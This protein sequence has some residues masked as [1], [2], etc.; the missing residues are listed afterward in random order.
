MVQT[1]H[2]GACVSLLL[3][4]NI[5]SANVIPLRELHFN[6]D[7][8]SESRGTRADE[9]YHL[10]K[11]VKPEFYKIT[12]T[13]NFDNFT[14]I[15]TVDITVSAPNGTD[16][17]S[18]HYDKI[19][20]DTVIV[21]CNN[22][23]IPLNDSYVE[24]TNIFTLELETPLISEE[25]C[26]IHIDYEGVL[27]DDMAG[28]YRSSYTTADGEERWL[29][30]T[31]FEPTD[32]RRAFPCFDEPGLKAAF[33]INIRRTKDLKSISNMNLLSSKD[34]ADGL[35]EDSFAVSPL[36]STYLV[37][38]IVSDFKQLS[39]NDDHHLYRIWVKGDALTQASYSMSISPGI[40][41]FMENFTAIQYK[42]P[43]LDQAAVPDFAAGAME[44]WGL[45]T[46][47]ERLLLYSEGTSTSSNKQNIASV[48][49]HEFAHQWFGDLVSP[50][51]WDYLWLN[52]GF[53]TYFEFFATQAVE[54]NW[55]LDHQFVV[56]AHQNALAADSSA[57]THP[58]TASVHT[59]AQINSIFDTISYDKAG[60]IIRTAEHFL[61][62]NTFVKGLR[63][64]LGI[65]AFEAATADDLFDALA[66]QAD[67][68][69][70]FQNDTDLNV[71]TILKS[72]TEQAGYPYI[73]VQ[74][75]ENGIHISQK[76]FLISGETEEEPAT[77]WWVPITY[78]TNNSI[79]FENTAP[80]VWLR[81]ISE[82]DI[83]LTLA[84][85]E[86][87]ILN[88]QETAFY[89]VIYD[90]VNYELLKDYLNS[91]NYI[92][93][94]PLNRAQLLDD[95]LYLARAGLL[96]YSTA[97]DLTT[98][99]AAETDFVPWVSFYRALTFLNT[100]FAGTEDYDLFKNY[101]LQLIQNLYRSVGF[102][103]LE[104]DE[105]P[106]KL[107]RVTTLTW[108]CN[109]NYDLCLN[110]ASALFRTWT[111]N[112][113][114]INRIPP[115]LRS[116]VYCSAVSNGGVDEWAFL[117][118]EFLKSKV[119]SDQVL[120][121]S[122]LGCTRDVTLLR[123][124]LTIAITPESK[125]RLQDAQT[126]FSA[127][128]SRP[129]GVDVAFDFLSNNFVAVQQYFAS[130]SGLRNIISGIASRMTTHAQHQKLSDFVSQHETDLG[131]ALAAA[132]AAVETVTVNLAWFDKYRQDI[133]EWMVAYTE[134][135]TSGPTTTTG[136]TTTTGPPTSET[137]ITTTD[138]GTSLSCN[139]LISI[140]ILT[141][142]MVAKY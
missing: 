36:M 81:N 131:S 133:S 112:T 105:H 67:A 90:D 107:I 9:D 138:A 94:H 84:D 135:T 57:T 89:R 7:R 54:P 68:D 71:K 91:D 2:L 141:G 79:D 59:P 75:T 83:E 122:A 22:V 62:H 52:E 134:T 95:S 86:W 109:F 102:N 44:N 114:R 119:A 63:R 123:Q 142:Y 40:I 32:A 55:R 100:R 77:T 58:I 23:E 27:H 28:F 33:Q 72:W 132:K 45:V 66:T 29:A 125:I 39:L 64:Y 87:V 111:D 80:K 97:L 129:E 60:S 93:I 41:E 48:I 4:I 78:T 128:Y 31:Q 47:R 20:V 53:A 115:D 137:P 110:S 103:A 121:L 10:P 42:F 104:Y 56:N 3:L 140:I 116:V 38:F 8:Y 65:K 99:L 108:A 46:Y 73:T 69:N 127:V 82:D 13:P 117:Y 70:I 96:S 101:V 120:I 88:I 16:S 124:Y 118:D 50:Q 92:N 98:Y 5:T 21:S 74:R 15:G 113:S 136:Q 18:L 49:A 6:P 51:W 12:L 17:I 37:A 25:S 76:K 19:T 130:T 30:A 11:T 106:T 85:N 126:V 34:T 1:W 139:P 14:F 24:A 26:I 35:V 43:K 61:T